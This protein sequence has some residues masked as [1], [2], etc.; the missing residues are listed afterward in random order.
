VRRP[1]ERTAVRPHTIRYRIRPESR[2]DHETLLAELVDALQRDPVPGLRYEVFRLGD[3]GLEYLHLVGFDKQS[4]GKLRRPRTLTDFHDGLRA[5]C[6]GEP[7]REELEPVAVGAP[8]PDPGA[9]GSHHD[10]WR[11]LHG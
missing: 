5:R 7:R 2:D 4:H 10:R 9:R 6:E 3:D 11:H 8:A 1:D